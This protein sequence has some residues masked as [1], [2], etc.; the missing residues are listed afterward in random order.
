RARAEAPRFARAEPPRGPAEMAKLAD[1]LS[2]ARA[3]IVLLGGSRW[4]QAASDA[5]ARFAQKHALPVATT[6]RRAHLF[7]ALHPCYAG[8]LGIGPNPKLLERIKAADLVILI[9]GRMGEL[10]SPSYTLVDI[11]R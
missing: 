9:G 6:F 5:V 7:D 4:S 8:D 2:A 3:P 10:P 1:M 11:P